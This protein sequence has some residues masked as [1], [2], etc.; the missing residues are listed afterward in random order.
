M[1]NRRHSREKKPEPVPVA[2]QGSR[3][4]PRPFTANDREAAPAMQPH[5][6]PGNAGHTFSQVQLTTMP[7]HM[8]T[9]LMDVAAG[10]HNR[11]ASEHA[12]AQPDSQANQLRTTIQ[13]KAFT[14]GHDLSFQ[15]PVQQHRGVVQRA[16]ASEAHRTNTTGLPDVLK[17]GVERLSGVSLDNVNVHY[18]SA[19]PAQLNALAY[20]QGNDIHIAPGQE[21][22]LPHEAWHVAQQAQG[23]VRST[24]QMKGGV[25]VNDDKGLEH[26]ADVMGRAAV[27]WGRNA[28]TQAENQSNLLRANPVSLGESKHTHPLVMQAVWD[29]YEPKIKDE[30][31]EDYQKVKGE[32]DAKKLEFAELDKEKN[33]TPKRWPNGN[34][35]PE[36]V[37]AKDRLKTLE[38]VLKG[39]ESKGAGGDA[40]EG[41]QNELVK[42]GKDVYG[43]A[44]QSYNK[45]G[46]KK[47]YLGRLLHTTAI[48]EQKEKEGKG[49]EK[50]VL[51]SGDWSLGVNDAFI[52]GGIDLQAR[53]KF[54]TPF[55]SAAK[56]IIANS[57]SGAGFLAA[58]QQNTP[59]TPD[60]NL[61]DPLHKNG[62]FPITVTTREIA[63]L[64]DAK[65][66]FHDAPAADKAKNESFQAFQTEAAYKEY[67]QE[68]T[69][70]RRMRRRIPK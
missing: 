7:L 56:K 66:V 38:G 34:K 17:S 31:A 13:A 47:L 28:S 42:A 53:F 62:A 55:S 63:Q 11:Q 16:E 5:T 49:A 50:R 4:E 12:A 1:S 24:M 26:E 57:T 70:E 43:Q 32:Y 33:A 40:A 59:N 2:E 3:F 30:A 39:W 67:L 44:E 69:E 22:H 41:R 52:G 29:T 60:D 15:Q 51:N 64:I 19:Q 54:K 68:K 20:A 45:T 21:Q 23:R 10:A 65:Y 36:W 6:A 37:G 27:R 8:Q 48:K 46:K 35:M 18:N 9:K 58:L 14:T 61:Y 25:P